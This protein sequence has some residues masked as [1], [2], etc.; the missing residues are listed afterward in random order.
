MSLRQNRSADVC[1]SLLAS[2][3]ISVPKIRQSLKIVPRKKSERKQNLALKK[4]YSRCPIAMN[5]FQENPNPI[6]SFGGENNILKVIERLFGHCFG[7]SRQALVHISSTVAAFQAGIFDSA[8]DKIR[9]IGLAGPLVLEPDFVVTWEGW[10]TSLCWW[11]HFL[12]GRPEDDQK[13]VLDLLFDPETGL[14]LNIVRYNIGGCPIYPGSREKT[15]NDVEEKQFRPPKGFKAVPGFKSSHVS[16]Y[17]WSADE[18]QRKILLAARDR[19]VNSFEAFSNSPPD[20]MTVTGSCTGGWNFGAENLKEENFEVFADY[21]TE[22]VLQYREKWGIKFDF[23]EP[24]NEP[25]EG[26]WV[27]GGSQEG[28]NFSPKSMDKILLLVSKFLTEKKLDT[29]LSGVDSWVENTPKVLSEF[30]PETVDALDRINVHGYYNF[31]PD[32]HRGERRRNLFFRKKMCELSGRL[33][34]KLWQ[35]EAGPMN[36]G[37]Q[38]ELTV[39]LRIGLNIILDVNQMH[40]SAWV[41]WQ[42]LEVPS[43]NF[44]GLLKGPFDLSGPFD[45]EIQKQYYIVLHFSRWIREGCQI[46]KMPIALDDHVLASYDPKKLLLSVIVINISREKVINPD[47]EFLGFGSKNSRVEIKSFCTSSK[48]NYDVLESTFVTLPC[49]FKLSCPKESIVTYV[50]EDVFPLKDF[51]NF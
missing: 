38:S 43:D 44:W 49:A 46:L 3:S 12:G 14:N 1:N 29:K 5:Q 18:N 35:S 32:G 51:E 20:W 45:V 11:A 41:Y 36:L 8:D 9:K 33:K 4:F 47:I 39:A 42:A 16:D 50:F 6:L 22:V 21:L 30:S 26:W 48:G 25:D 40:V 17:D 23:L 28:C 2:D 31:K 27:I 24:F 13:K 37:S 10:G 34:K 7:L 19:G 15:Q